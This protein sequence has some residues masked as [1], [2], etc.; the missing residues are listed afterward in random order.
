MIRPCGHY[1]GGELLLRE[2][3]GESKPPEILREDLP[4]VRRLVPGCAHVGRIKPRGGRVYTLYVWL[5]VIGHLSL[6]ICQ[7]SVVSCQW[8]V[9]S[10]LIQLVGS[11]GN[12]SS[13]LVSLKSRGESG[14]SCPTAG[15]TI[16][17]PRNAF[18]CALCVF[19][20]LRR[21]EPRIA[22]RHEGAKSAKEDRVRRFAQ[23]S[24]MQEPARRY[25]FFKVR[26]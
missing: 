11:R 12:R 1:A 5:V 7:W 21:I 10:C 16:S 22:Q 13:G 8:S 6:V 19:V 4:S 18:L 20:T 15:G 14:G 17:P 9:V 3:F 2:P 23:I 25:L 24:Q 26:E